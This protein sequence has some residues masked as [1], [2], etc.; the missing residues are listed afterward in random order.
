MIWIRATGDYCEA[1]SDESTSLKPLVREALGEPVRRIG[2][3]IQLA[4]IGSGRCVGEARLDPESAVYTSSARGDLDVTLEVVE[5]LFRHGMQPKPLSFVN[6]VSN[7][8]NF[9]IAHHFDLAGRSNFVC[10]AFFA[11][12]SVLELACVD[13]RAGYMDSALVGSVDVATWPMADHRRR[14]QVSDD[15]RMAEGSHWLWLQRAEQAPTGA[16]GEVLAAR[17]FNDSDALL[18]WLEQQSLEPAHTVLGGGQFLAPGVLADI[19]QRSGLEQLFEGPEYP[20]YY[21][22]QSGAA[23]SCFL[24]RP[25]APYLLHINGEGDGPRLAIMLVRRL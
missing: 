1:V 13:M 14:L 2:R 9:Y 21:D 25:G 8:P 15:T 11:F 7:A 18:G 4:L 22:S 3:F 6:S 20:G 10:S 5:A 24:S 19:Q 12:E 17:Q 23:I 16:L